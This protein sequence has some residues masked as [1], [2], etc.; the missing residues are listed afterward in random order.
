M[1]EKLEYYE[2]LIEE[3]TNANTDLTLC[4]Y[5]TKQAMADKASLERQTD[6]L[7]IANRELK[8]AHQEV[9]HRLQTQRML[10]EQYKDFVR[11]NIDVFDF[12]KYSGHEYEDLGQ[13]KSAGSTQKKTDPVSSPSV[14]NI[15]DQMDIF[16][17]VR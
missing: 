15:L 5:R 10:F 11:T 2:Q 17:D 9:E 14:R 8:A 7:I 1:R 4:L 13:M 16:S 3:V 6:E 12:D